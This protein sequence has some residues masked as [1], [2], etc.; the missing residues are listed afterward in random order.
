MVAHAPIPAFAAGR[1]QFSPT[2]LF[3]LGMQF[4]ALSDTATGTCPTTLRQPE[5]TVT[6]AHSRLVTVGHRYARENGPLSLAGRFRNSCPTTTYRAGDRTRTGDVQLGKETGLRTYV[7]L[8]DGTRRE[9]VHNTPPQNGGSVAENGFG[10]PSV[11]P[12]CLA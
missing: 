8:Y 4:G 9:D 11:D 12:H 10:G 6:S 2:R 1:L 3:N 5:S 7:R